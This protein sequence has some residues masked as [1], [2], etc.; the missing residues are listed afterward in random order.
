[1]KCDENWINELRWNQIKYEIKWRRRVEKGWIKL[2]KKEDVPGW[3]NFERDEIGK[4][5]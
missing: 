4:K 2:K 5:I 1:M 3:K